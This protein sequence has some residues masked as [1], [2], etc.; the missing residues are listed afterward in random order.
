MESFKLVI[1]GLVNVN[2]RTGMAV[3][4]IVAYHP[5]LDVYDVKV[6]EC[7]KLFVFTGKDLA[8]WN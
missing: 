2:L 4:R 3:G 6:G 7:T 1:G 8:T 5:E